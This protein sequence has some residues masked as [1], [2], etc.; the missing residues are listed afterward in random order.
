MIL[1]KRYSG[2]RPVNHSACMCN[3]YSIT[4]QAAIIAL[5]RVVNRYVGN[6]PPMPGEFPDYP[7]PVV[8]NSDAGPRPCR[9]VTHA[10]NVRFFP[11]SS[12]DCHRTITETSDFRFGDVVGDRGSAEIKYTSASRTAD[13]SR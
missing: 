2:L 6:L 7:A 13:R 10:G 1:M 4:N 9:F 8:R 12:V 3:L 5:F 11:R